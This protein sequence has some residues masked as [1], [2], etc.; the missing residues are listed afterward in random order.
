VRLLVSKKFALEQWAEHAAALRNN[1]HRRL[2]P[3][4]GKI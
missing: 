1:K 4:G 3:S 2:A